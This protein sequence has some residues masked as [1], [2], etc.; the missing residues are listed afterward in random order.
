MTTEQ[1]FQIS[2][3]V[4]LLERYE[5]VANLL[6]A[7]GAATP[8]RLILQGSISSLLPEIFKGGFGRL[9]WGFGPILD[10]SVKLDGEQLKKMCSRRKQKSQDSSGWEFHP[11][12]FSAAFI[13]RAIKVNITIATTS[14]MERGLPNKA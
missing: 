6:S 14:P 8:S 13:L 5:G 2:N 10:S 12:I 3:N 9:G 1:P 11:L 7:F 4:V